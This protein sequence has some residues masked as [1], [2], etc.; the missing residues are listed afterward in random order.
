MKTKKMCY[1]IKFSKKIITLENLFYKYIDENRYLGK[2]NIKK[3]LNTIKLN[4]PEFWF[5][6]ISEI[7]E[8]ELH[9]IFEYMKN[10]GKKKESLRLSAYLKI[11][12]T[13]AQ[14]NDINIQ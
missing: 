12:L 10:T 8:K 11:L 5:I 4:I 3:M 7:N 13:F 6:S 9:Q 2:K 1:S 14:N